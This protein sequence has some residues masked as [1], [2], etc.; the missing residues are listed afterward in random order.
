MCGHEL[1]RFNGELLW[2]KSALR[3][4]PAVPSPAA[5]V[6]LVDGPSRRDVKLVLDLIPE[7]TLQTQAFHRHTPRTLVGMSERRGCVG[8]ES[9]RRAPRHADAA[10]PGTSIQHNIPDL[11]CPSR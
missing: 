8:K 2:S 6:L 1:I 3:L 10:K 11:S 7:G 9:L 4:Y 5:M